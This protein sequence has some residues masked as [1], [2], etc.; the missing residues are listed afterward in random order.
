[1]AQ[2][3][4]EL[5]KPY[6]SLGLGEPPTSSIV[7]YRYP[8]T[9]V[10]EICIGLHYRDFDKGQLTFIRHDLKNYLRAFR[11]HGISAE[12]A[13][14][15]DDKFNQIP[16]CDP[17]IQGSLCQHRSTSRVSVPLICGR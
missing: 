17:R 7:A 4:R 9:H 14:L 1:M 11:Q 16:L 8:E 12:S 5:L 13:K 3:L 2:P 10:G 15:A 6:R